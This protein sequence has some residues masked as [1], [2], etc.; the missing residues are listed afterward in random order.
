MRTGYNR[1]NHKDDKT[2]TPRQR[3]TIARRL[4]MAITG[5]AIA[6]IL[7]LSIGQTS[8][9]SKAADTYNKYY[10]SIAVKPGD[11]LSDYYR[12]YGE[13]YD[14]AADYYQE[15]SIQVRFMGSREGLPDI[16]NEKMNHAIEATKDN[17]GIILNLAINYGGQAEILHAVKS[18]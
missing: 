5:V 10:T 8:L 1:F 4:Y 13:R 18:S 6:L 2:L 9:D 7:I 11:T 12:T 15:G 3:Q 17:N 14:C 16:V